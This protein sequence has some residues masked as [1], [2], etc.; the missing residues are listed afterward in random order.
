VEVLTRH[1]I[2]ADAIIS[3]AAVPGKR[4]PCIISTTMVEEMKHGAVIIDLA[5]ESGGN[6]ELT[7]PGEAF[8]HGM[9]M[10]Y[11]PLNVPALLP[12]HASE[13]YA[14]NLFNFLSLLIHDGELKPD[15]DDEIIA[16]SVLTHGGRIM[17][18]PTR[19][20]VEGGQS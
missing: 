9:V 3:T 20:L 5:A 18:E 1:V 2:G 6:C 13:M 16:A 19:L 7:V 10:I 4:A 11:G 8:G 12:V 17:H 14:K 15:W